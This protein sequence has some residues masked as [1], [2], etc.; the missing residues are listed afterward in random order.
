MNIIYY[1]NKK[2]KVNRKFFKRVY[3]YNKHKNKEKKNI[4]TWLIY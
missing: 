4:K 3:L 2:T 1:K